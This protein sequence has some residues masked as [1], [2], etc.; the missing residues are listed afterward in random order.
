[1]LTNCSVW[2]IVVDIKT[3]LF[4]NALFDTCITTWKGR[5]EHMSDNAPT[6]GK[7]AGKLHNT[8]VYLKQHWQLYLIFILPAVALTI[9]FR[10]I[11]MGGILIAFKNYNPIKGIWGS[12]WVSN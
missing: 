5:R 8:L 3:A 4:A 6:Q 11:P 9:I 1:M 12:K 2:C 10:Y 7:S